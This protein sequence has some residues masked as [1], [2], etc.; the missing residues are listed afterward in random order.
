MIQETYNPNESG[1]FLQQFISITKNRP[2]FSSNVPQEY[3]VWAVPQGQQKTDKACA[4][5]G[6]HWLGL[7]WC[8]SASNQTM[9]GESHVTG[10]RIVTFQ[11]SQCGFCNSYRCSCYWWSFVCLSKTTITWLA[12]MW[13]LQCQVQK[14]LLLPAVCCWCASNCCSRNG[15]YMVVPSCSFGATGAS[16]CTSNV[17]LRVFLYWITVTKTY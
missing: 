10:M 12:T 1:T 4:I 15:G 14:V 13:A 8:C 5:Y 7:R 11:Q 9:K 17:T 6:K 16:N 3:P 2:D